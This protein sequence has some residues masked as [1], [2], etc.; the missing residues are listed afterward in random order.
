MMKRFIAIAIVLLSSTAMF[1]KG[2][3]EPDSDLYR[4]GVEAIKDK[5]YDKGIDLLNQELANNPKNGYPSLNVS[6]K[7]K[8]ITN[9]AC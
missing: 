3:K 9:V 8:S 6:A 5:K 4:R 2:Q 7:S 1:A